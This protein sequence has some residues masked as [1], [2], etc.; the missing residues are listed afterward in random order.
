MDFH[1][2]FT[3]FFT[4]FGL[5]CFLESMPWILIPNKIREALSHLLEQSDDVLRMYGISLLLIG[6]FIMWLAS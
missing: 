3:L 5:A 1:F 2:N 6:L 4:A